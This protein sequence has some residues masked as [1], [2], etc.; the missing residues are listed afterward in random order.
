VAKSRVLNAN[1]FYMYH[2]GIVFAAAHMLGYWQVHA[3]K[4]PQSQSRRVMWPALKA[5]LQV[6]L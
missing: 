1:C 2:L 5:C 6:V 3:F 4:N